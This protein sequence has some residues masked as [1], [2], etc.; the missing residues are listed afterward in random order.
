MRVATRSRKARSWV[1]VHHAA[2]EVEQQVFEPLDRVEV[3]VVGGF[4]E[5][6][7]VGPAHQRLRQRDALAVAAGERA[8]ARVRVE[9]QAVQGLVDALLPVPAVLAPRSRLCSASQVAVAVRVLRR[10]GR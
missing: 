2:V 5:Q 9:V 6:Q 4:V 10:S 8:D 7:H 1:I 3:Q